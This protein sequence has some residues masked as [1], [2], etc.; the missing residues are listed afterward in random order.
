MRWRLR[1]SSHDVGPLLPQLWVGDDLGGQRGSAA[2]GQG[3]GVS[4]QP[5]VMDVPVC[6]LRLFDHIDEGLAVF[7]VEWLLDEDRVVVSFGTPTAVVCEQW[8]GHFDDDPVY[9]IDFVNAQ[10]P[11]YSPRD[12]LR[13]IRGGEPMIPQRVS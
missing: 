10:D 12:K 7:R 13:V 1:G 3:A 2:A 5:Q 11:E 8:P 9:R 4:D 6:S